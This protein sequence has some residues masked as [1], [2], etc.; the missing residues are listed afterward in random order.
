MG[1]IFPAPLFFTG[2]NKEQWEIDERKKLEESLHN[3]IHTIQITGGSRMVSKS[4]YID[5]LI[6]EMKCEKYRKGE[7]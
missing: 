4:V 2:A 3:G 6:S 7:V 5:H 1:S